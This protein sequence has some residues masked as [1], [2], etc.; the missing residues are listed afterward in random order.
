VRRLL[1]TV[2]CLATFCSAA[3]ANL[4]ISGGSHGVVPDAIQT[5]DI[6]VTG[7]GE[8]VTTT[9]LWLQI[10][11]GS[12]AWPEITNVDITGSGTLFAENNNG[13]PFFG[14]TPNRR[15]WEAKTTTLDGAIA[16]TGQRLLARVT[17]D[18]TGATLG[19]II[20]FRLTNILPEVWGD[21]GMSSN[22]GLAEHVVYDGAITV[23]Y[24]GDFNLDGTV[25]N[26]D[27]GIWFAN[28]GAGTTWQTG[29]ANNDGVVNGDDYDIWFAN[30]GSN[31]ASGQSRDIGLAHL[32]SSKAVP[33]PGTLALL[34]PVVALFGCIVV[35]GR[36]K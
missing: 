31:I 26:D 33:E 16:V 14:Y 30:L 27:H 15:N 11:D 35:R 34:L 5:I 22:M 36:R 2:L 17:L 21:P 1:F 29:D 10:G 4:V 12:D 25:N 6:F 32:A 3:H 13:K 24:G 18:T 28:A 19:Q 9:D 20:P 7:G 23:S 8:M